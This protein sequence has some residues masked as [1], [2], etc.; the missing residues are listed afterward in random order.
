MHDNSSNTL[1][2]IVVHGVMLMFARNQRYRAG[3]FRFDTRRL[4]ASGK[5]PF[6]PLEAKKKVKRK[7]DRAVSE[8]VMMR[9]I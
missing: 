5:N 8:E 3:M 1:V 6:P 7:F 2:P 9:V 4:I